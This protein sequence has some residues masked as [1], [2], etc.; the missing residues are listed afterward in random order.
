MVTGSLREPVTLWQ[1]Q[2]PRANIPICTLMIAKQKWMYGVHS[3]ERQ[4]QL[5]LGE[6]LGRGLALR[7]PQHVESN[8]FR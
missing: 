7:D 6:G 1:H 8:G 5:E 4:R 2:A 3:V